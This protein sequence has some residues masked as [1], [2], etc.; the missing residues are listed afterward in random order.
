MSDMVSRP[1]FKKFAFLK[2]ENILVAVYVEDLKQSIDHNSK[3]LSVKIGLTKE[4]INMDVVN[5]TSNKTQL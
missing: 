2:A 1:T 4:V 5:Q 3:I